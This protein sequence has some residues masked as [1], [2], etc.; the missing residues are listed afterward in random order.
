MLSESIIS[1]I[2]SQRIA[3]KEQATRAQ[4]QCC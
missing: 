1:G 3:P 4:A 2:D